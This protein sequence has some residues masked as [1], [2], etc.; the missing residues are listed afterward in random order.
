MD[1][2]SANEGRAAAGVGVYAWVARP[3]LLRWAMASASA[4]V[5]E[6]M[7]DEGVTVCQVR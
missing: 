7:V 1:M 5:V 3:S 2:H 4:D 6:L